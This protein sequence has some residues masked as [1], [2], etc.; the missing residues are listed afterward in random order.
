MTWTQ[1]TLD[2]DV[3]LSRKLPSESLEP[4]LIEYARQDAKA[5][6][7]SLDSMVRLTTRA[8]KEKD[9]N[10]LRV[11]SIDIINSNSTPRTT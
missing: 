10:K 5:P 2:S 9:P 7:V 8:L 6:N 1:Y 11:H 3:G 4:H